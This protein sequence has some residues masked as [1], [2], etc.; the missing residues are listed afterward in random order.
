MPAF[1][2]IAAFTARTGEEERVALLVRDLAEQV[3]A[4]PGNRIFEP[5]R[6]RE[7]LRGFLVYE[8]YV[9]ADAF[10]AHLAALHTVHFNE[11]LGDLIEEDH[12]Q[13]TWL[14]RVV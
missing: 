7:N 6:H 9:D 13:L 11:V 4:E 10:A 1:T 2:L 5:S 12:S 8:D 14:D 3:R